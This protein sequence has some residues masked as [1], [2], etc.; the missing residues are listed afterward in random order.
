T[1]LWPLHRF[2][3]ALSPSVLLTA[4]L[5]RLSGDDAVLNSHVHTDGQHSLRYHQGSALRYALAGRCISPDRHHCSRTTSRL[6]FW[7][8]RSCLSGCHLLLRCACLFRLR[9]KLP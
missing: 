9:L 6:H 5:L 4:P 1:C 8:A 7:H 2:F 3:H